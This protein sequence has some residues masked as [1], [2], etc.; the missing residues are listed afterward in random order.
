MTTAPSATEP[1]PPP[2][3]AEALQRPRPRI[4]GVDLAR[5][6]AIVGMVMVHVLPGLAG[7]VEGP[8]GWVYG[9]ASTLF[10]LVAGVGI[11]LSAARRP[12]GQVRARLLYRAAWLAPLGVWMQSLDHPVAVILHYY[13]LWFLLTA[14]VVTWSDRALLALTGVGL[15]VGPTLLV[16]AQQL[17]P[18]WYDPPGAGAVLGVFG[19]VL[20]T[21]YYPSVSW[22]WLV[23]AGLLLGRRDLGSTRT[24]GRLLVGGTVVGVAT[25]VGVR[26][27]A[28]VVDLGRWQPLLSVEGHADTTLETLAAGAIATAVLAACLL[29]GQTLPRWSLSPGVAFGRLALTIYVGHVLL[30][31]AVPPLLRSATVA[32]GARTTLWLTVVSTVFAVAWLAWRPRGPLEGAEHW[33][34]DRVVLPLVGDGRAPGGRGPVERRGTTADGAGVVARRMPGGDREGP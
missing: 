27:L 14:L 2:P 21:G 29:V 28:D 19:D 3:P 1:P 17:R 4:A 5:G 6:L 24:A 18:A 31:A 23:L 34:F 13:A 33:V 26:A 10:A 9:R 11:A 16:V 15:L 30:Y 8:Y 25:Y 22:W 7:A 12:S 20:L 32:E